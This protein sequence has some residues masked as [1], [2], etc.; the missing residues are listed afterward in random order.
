MRIAFLHIPK[1]AGQSVHYSLTSLFDQ[2]QICPARTNEQLYKYS[3]SELSRFSLFS[4]H[5]D[6]SIVRLSGSFDFVFTVLRDPLDRILSFYFYLRKEAERL[7]QEG[8]PVGAGMKAVLQYSP[9]Q[10]FT[11]D[12]IGIRMFLD[13]HYNNF[14]SY[15]FASGSYSG[16][17]QLSSA[18]PPGSK[19]LLD[20]ADFGLRSLD[21]IYT[22][23]SLYKLTTDINN[24]FRVDMLAIA[25]VNVNRQVLP[26]KRSDSLTKLAGDWDWRPALV[27]LAKSDNLIFQK[28]GN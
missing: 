18:F 27:E 11:G 21:A 12:D 3:I 15:Y 20:Y 16:F 25:E 8:E 19:D 13:N 10:Y 14:Y 22:L 6:W 4:G 7:Q 1:T 2:N 26:S 24:L 9:R 28:Y 23:S 17:S 5:L